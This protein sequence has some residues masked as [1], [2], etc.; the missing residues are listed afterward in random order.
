M[1]N[2][3]SIIEYSYYFALNGGNKSFVVP[4]VFTL[5]EKVDIDVLKKSIKETYK[6]FERYAAKP[7]IKKDGSI[8]LTENE[9]E[10][11][12][13]DDIGSIY[14]GTK[15]SNKYLHRIVVEDNKVTFS[16]GH[17]MGDGYG[18]LA[19][20]ENVLHHY[21]NFKGENP[22][23]TDKI[24]TKEDIEKGI[25]TVSLI[26]QINAKYDLTPSDEKSIN[27]ELFKSSNDKNKKYV[28]KLDDSL[29]S[30]KKFYRES[31]IFDAKAFMNIVHKYNATPITFFYMLLSEAIIERYKLSDKKVTAGIACDMRR[32]LDS[33]SQNNF[34]TLSFISYDSA[35]G[36]LSIDEQIRLIRE[37]FDIYLDIKWLKYMCKFFATY[38]NTTIGKFNINN[39]DK[40]MKDMEGDYTRTSGGIFI[41]NNGLIK[42]SDVLNSHILDFEL[43]NTPTKNDYEI[44][45]T[46]YK[47]KGAF[48]LTLNGVDD[49][50]FILILDGLK[51]Q[52]I[53]ARYVKRNLIETDHVNPLL[54]D[55]E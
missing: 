11:P 23:H 30:S 10:I 17:S 6:Y 18:M 43:I 54:F 44:D 14:L 53:E 4:W 13:S 31:I 46:T 8:I 21:Y 7:L 39:Y 42:F 5:D 36:K 50:I 51:R 45:I 38:D 25:H 15:E 9:N 28:M 41:S 35:W 19:F 37:K 47:D 1:K 40:L 27:E 24:Y 3:L 20:C 2:Q 48:D 33:R 55:K 26:E 12:I 29:F 49:D 52:N 22:L 16:I 34:G 32:Y